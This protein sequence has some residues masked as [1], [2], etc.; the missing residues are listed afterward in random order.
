MASIFQ[1]EICTWGRNALRRHCLLT[2]LIQQGVQINSERLLEVL[3]IQK[4][5][6]ELQYNLEWETWIKSFQKESEKHTDLIFV[7]NCS[8]RVRLIPNPHFYT[9]PILD[10]PTPT[11]T[12][13]LP[14]EHGPHEISFSDALKHQYSHLLPKCQGSD[15]SHVFLKDVQVTLFPLS[16]DV[17]ILLLIVGRK[18]SCSTKTCEYYQ[19]VKPQTSSRQKQF[20]L[21]VSEITKL[22]LVE[23]PAPLVS[24]SVKQRMKR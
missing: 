14:R 24:K 6:R 22:H 12:T 20:P 11:P 9:L 5:M 21:R 4:E 3:W 15:L 8:L 1:T 19:H 18:A 2:T 7:L 16:L 23:V 17:F 13:P 10:D